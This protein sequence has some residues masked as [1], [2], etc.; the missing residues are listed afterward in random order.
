MIGRTNAGGGKVFAAISVKYPVGADCTASL[1]ADES[2]TIILMTVHAKKRDGMELFMIP[3]GGLWHVSAELAGATTYKDVTVEQSQTYQITLEPLYIVKA[4]TMQLPISNMS[5]PR[6]STSENGVWRFSPLMSNDRPSFIV[7]GPFDA[8]LYNTLHCNVVGGS[9]WY[10]RT[11]YV[12]ISTSNVLDI[13][14]PYYAVLPHDGAANTRPFSKKDTI[15]TLP[16]IGESEISE[17][18]FTVGGPTIGQSTGSSFVEFD[19]I[20]LTQE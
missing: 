18:Y 20:Y 12:G 19:N 5:D 17:W 11:H 16:T 10:T 8:R 4:G 3:Q 15:L 9:H 2:K 1:Y 13:P 7:V 6:S 14:T